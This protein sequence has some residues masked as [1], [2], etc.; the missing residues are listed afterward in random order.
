MLLCQIPQTLIH[1]RS[2]AKHALDCL[3]FDVSFTLLVSGAKHGSR[4]GDARVA[5]ER[6]RERNTERRGSR[7]PFSFRFRPSL[8]VCQVIFLMSDL[9]AIWGFSKLSSLNCWQGAR[10]A[11]SH[12]NVFCFGRSFRCFRLVLL[13]FHWTVCRSWHEVSRHVQYGDSN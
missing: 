10:F 11:G 3:S 4:T 13:V 1:S 2:R 9:E 8:H 7:P 5:K 12:V 6:E